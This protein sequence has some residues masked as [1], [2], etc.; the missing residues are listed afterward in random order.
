MHVLVATFTFRFH[1]GGSTTLRGF[2]MWGTG[3]QDTGYSLGGEAYW[4][5]G[6]HLYHP[7]PFLQGQI[8]EFL[9]THLFLTT[10]NLF[11][12]G[13]YI[14]NFAC[15]VQY[16]K[17]A[18]DAL[19]HGELW[20]VLQQYRLSLGLGLLLRVG[21]GRLELNYCIPLRAQSSDR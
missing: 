13:M 18:I 4:A 14:F 20:G 1:L 2:D 19:S 5:V 21:I 11:N 8:N 6:L 17:W 9:K 10:G 16:A 12:Y 15:H 7:L 3:P